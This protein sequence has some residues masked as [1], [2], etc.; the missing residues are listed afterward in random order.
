V[1][2][3]KSFYEVLGVPEDASDEDIRT[4]YRKLAVKVH[5][6]KNPG[7]KQAEER[8]KEL[9][10]AYAVLSDTDKRAMYDRQLRGGFATGEVPGGP[11]GFGGF[12]GFGGGG[13]DW[14]AFSIDEILRRFG[15]MFGGF[16]GG[17]GRGFR[18][19]GQ[20]VEASVTVPFR[21]AAL[22]DHVE[23]S[24]SGDGIPK[25]VSL[26]I[27]EGTQDGATLRLRG[28]GGPGLGGGPAGDLFLRIRVTPDREFRAKG[29]DVESDLKVSAPTAALGG[30]VT[31]K[32]LRGEATVTIPPGTSS[33]SVLR[34]RGQGIRGGD[35]LV[36]VLVTVPSRPTAE[37]TR[38]YEQLRDLE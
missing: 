14:E 33:G 10:Q 36:R 23:V 19:A 21:T 25:K 27:P 3:G 13:G 26:K 35:H 7:D 38:L 6:D 12:G 15:G 2:R 22:G 8:F 31:A 1:A 32:T 29:H 20:D 28:M 18:G 30:K 9:A 17:G 5:P 4:A 11:G 37:E 16:E 24:L 34:L